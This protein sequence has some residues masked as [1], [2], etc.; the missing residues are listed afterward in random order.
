MKRNV[1]SESE[2]E[3][4]TQN[5][6]KA[7]LDLG[8]F[9]DQAFKIGREAENS[10][11]FILYQ[12]SNKDILPSY[13]RMMEYCHMAE[14]YFKE[15]H[16]KGA[17][18]RSETM[19]LYGWIQ[20]KELAEKMKAFEKR[21]S[22]YERKTS[23]FWLDVALKSEGELPYGGTGYINSEISG[24]TPEKRFENFLRKNHL[25]PK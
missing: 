10:N 8:R 9:I 22:E 12:K 5:L 19:L 2:K 21:F 11:L 13:G 24:S 20:F 15:L 4:Y 23:E 7:A 3:K 25:A 1:K 6:R 14:A 18:S 17:L 16:P